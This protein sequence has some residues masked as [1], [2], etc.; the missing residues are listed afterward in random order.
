MTFSRILT[1][2]QTPSIIYSH[3][4]YCTALYACSV[5]HHGSYCHISR[6]KWTE[7][8]HQK[9]CSGLLL[10]CVTHKYKWFTQSCS[11]WKICCSLSLYL[12]MVQIWALNCQ[13]TLFWYSR[14]LCML[15]DFCFSRKWHF[16]EV[17]WEHDVRAVACEFIITLKIKYG[18]AVN[19]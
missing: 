10:F 9:S 5:E 2:S 11:C 14:W 16:V 18:N 8:P 17:F 15:I 13:C 6:L 1:S 4:I 19:S 12:S 7:L 3:R